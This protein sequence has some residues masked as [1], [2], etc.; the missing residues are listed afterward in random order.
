MLARHVRQ[1]AG[2]SK[3]IHGGRGAAGS[4][5]TG[6]S[7]SAIS[8]QHRSEASR[9][10]VETADALAT[11]LHASRALL[12]VAARPEAPDPAH[13]ARAIAGGE[14]GGDGGAPLISS[15]QHRT[16]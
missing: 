12:L 11:R 16:A 1:S 7:D 5:P 3:L 15:A 10:V 2:G 9:I 4:C 8:G 14:G 6:K 13:D